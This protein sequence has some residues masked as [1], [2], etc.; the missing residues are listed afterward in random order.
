MATLNAISAPASLRPDRFQRSH[1]SAA[2]RPASPRTPADPRWVLAAAAIT[3]LDGGRAAIL[4]P[5]RRRRLMTTAVALGLRE[6][7]AS[8][9]IAIVQDAA[10]RG[11]P[12]NAGAASSL[13]MVAPARPIRGAGP[14]LA[15]SAVLG[16]AWAALLS[17][18]E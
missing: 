9:I 11:E 4:A 2:A 5:A 1:A 13:A 15:L 17:A 18:R 3:A 6:F 10:R 16:L 14:L 12:L 8:L 7:D